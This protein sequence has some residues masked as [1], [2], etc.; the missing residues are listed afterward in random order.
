[1]CSSSAPCIYHPFLCAS[2]RQ[3]SIFPIHYL[4]YLLLNRLGLEKAAKAVK[5]WR[6]KGLRPLPLRDC[7][8]RQRGQLDAREEQYRERS[9]NRGVRWEAWGQQEH[10]SYQRS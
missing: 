3:F 4:L 10:L 2:S 5:Y 9:A 7:L 8:R 6:Y 1:M